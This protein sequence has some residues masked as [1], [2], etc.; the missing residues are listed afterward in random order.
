[1]VG[2]SS[3]SIGT[4]LSSKFLRISF[5]EQWNWE[6]GEILSWV[7]SILISLATYYWWDRLD[8]RTIKNIQKKYRL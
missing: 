3:G 4:Y 7:I 1:M 2:Q 8:R 6:Y 5:V